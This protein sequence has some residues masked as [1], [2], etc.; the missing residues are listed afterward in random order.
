[1]GFMPVIDKMMSHETMSER[2]ERQTLMFSATFPDEIQKAASKFLTNYVFLT[3]GVVGGANTDVEQTIFEVT[4]F[5][6]RK[7]INVSFHFIFKIFI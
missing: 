6:K 3:V 7:K 4:K 1:M 2:N 5:E